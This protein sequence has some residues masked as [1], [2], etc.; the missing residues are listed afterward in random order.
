[1]QTIGIFAKKARGMMARFLIEHR[2]TEPEDLKKFDKNG[3]IFREDLSDGDNWIY[4]HFHS[5]P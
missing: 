3:Y 4:T 5:E 1:M 2:V